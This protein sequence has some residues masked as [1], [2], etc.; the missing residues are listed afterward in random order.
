MCTSTSRHEVALSFSLLAVPTVVDHDGVGIVVTANGFNSRFVISHSGLVDLVNDVTRLEAD[1]HI[2]GSDTD[3]EVLA[4]LFVEAFEEGLSPAEATK[5]VMSQIDGAYA[6]AVLAK[7]HSDMLI[8]ARNASPLAIG[9]GDGAC[10]I[11]SDAIALAHL[12]RRVIYLKDHD[13]A[14]VSADNVAVFDANAVPVNRE[15]VI[16]AASPGLVDKGG[17]RHYMEKEIH[18]QPDAI[19]HS[20]AAMTGADGRLAEESPKALYPHLDPIHDLANGR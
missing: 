19:A 16:V 15:E 1:G 8:V 4:H 10:F 11:G 17:Y 2:F 20:L 14:L 6:F 9:I 5:K 12:T 18:E 7:A 13:F 3:S